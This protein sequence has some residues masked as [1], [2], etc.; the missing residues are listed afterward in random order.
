[1]S[2]KKNP[3]TRCLMLRSAW[4]RPLGSSLRP[5]AGGHDLSLEFMTM[6]IT[7]SSLTGFNQAVNL[8][9]SI[10]HLQNVSRTSP[11]RLQNVSRTCLQNV[12]PERVSR[13]SHLFA[14]NRI[15]KGQRSV[16]GDGSAHSDECS[17]SGSF[18]RFIRFNGT[19]PDVP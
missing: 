15:S 16:S 2:K 6:L 12:S 18:Q 9:L 8:S 5:A 7:L 13:T 1:M 14:H 4:I 11:E 10:N 3:L 17:V 19:F